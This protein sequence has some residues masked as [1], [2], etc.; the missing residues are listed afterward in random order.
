MTTEEEGVKAIIALQFLT[1]VRE[2]EEQAKIGWNGMNE[3]EQEFTIKVHEALRKLHE[4]IAE[5][6]MSDDRP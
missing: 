5:A 2:T 4:G 1:G 3:E 6:D